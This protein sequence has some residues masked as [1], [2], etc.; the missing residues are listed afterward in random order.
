MSADPSRGIG[1]PLE[2]RALVEY[3]DDHLDK[4][5]ERLERGAAPVWEAQAEMGRTL[6]ALSSGAI[7]VSVSVTQL[8]MTKVT[9]LHWAWLLPTAWILFGISVLA[10]VSRQG[11]TGSA[12]AFRAYLEQKRA[13][14]RQQLWNLDP[15]PDFPDRVDKILE[16]AMN[17]ANVE[18]GKAIKVHGALNQVVFWTFAGGLA[19]LVAFAIKNLPS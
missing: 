4:T 6:I 1:Q 5:M 8:F 3:I 9:G 12:R 17:D 18:P 14:I 10:G 2:G 19:G 16:A 13:E 11:W 7:V 15:G